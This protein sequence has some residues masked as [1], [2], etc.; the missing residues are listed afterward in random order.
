MAVRGVAA[1]R[2]RQ[3]VAH[4][5]SGGAE[6]EHAHDAAGATRADAAQ[7]DADQ[8]QRA[9]EQPDDEGGRLR[10]AGDVVQ[11]VRPP[12]A[13]ATRAEDQQDAGDDET[14]EPEADRNA[15]TTR[16]AVRRRSGPARLWAYA[17]GKN[18]VGHH[19]PALG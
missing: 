17:G 2:W 3:Q 16:L 11:P 10:S 19:D 12:V 6:Q 15:T 1:E 13:N 5:E 7:H 4:D 9:D 8:R 18:V 14:Q